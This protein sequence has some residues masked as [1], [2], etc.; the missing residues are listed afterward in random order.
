MNRVTKE[1]KDREIFSC[2]LGKLMFNEQN[3][4]RSL[5]LSKLEQENELTQEFPLSGLTILCRENSY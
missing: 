4:E 5:D 1:C 3:L 2:I